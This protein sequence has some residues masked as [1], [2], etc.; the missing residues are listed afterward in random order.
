MKSPFLFTAAAL[1]LSLGIS[2]LRRIKVIDSC[3]FLLEKL[4][5]Y[6]DIYC[7]KYTGIY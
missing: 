2:V 1:F 4:F 3:P 6:T 7:I 5:K